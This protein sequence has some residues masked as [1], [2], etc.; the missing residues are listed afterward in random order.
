MQSQLLKDQEVLGSRSQYTSA[1]KF[2]ILIFSLLFNS[3]LDTFSSLNTGN[4]EVTSIWFIFTE[5]QLCDIS[6]INQKPQLKEK[7][8]GFLEKASSQEGV[9][10][11]SF[12]TCIND[13]QIQSDLIGDFLLR[14][15][16]LQKELFGIDHDSKKKLS[17]FKQTLIRES[18]EKILK[19]VQ[20]GKWELKRG[21]TQVQD[22]RIFEELGLD[23]QLIEFTYKFDLQNAKQILEHLQK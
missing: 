6:L 20:S 16:Q 12:F 17:Y 8:F 13:T 7:V 22:L 18:Y 21:E 15:A 11:L 4:S 2:Q 10:S 14:N 3:F 5:L 23:Q 9:K 19:K 1:Q